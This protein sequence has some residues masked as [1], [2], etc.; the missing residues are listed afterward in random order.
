LES[1]LRDHIEQRAR[2]GAAPPA[3]FEEAVKALG[4]ANALKQEF[5]KVRSRVHKRSFNFLFARIC[6]WG[7]VAIVGAVGGWAVAQTETSIEA[8]ALR[9]AVMLVTVLYFLKLPYLYR[10][11]S[12]AGVV[13]REIIRFASILAWPAWVYSVPAEGGP[14]L[15]LALLGF[16]SIV[17]ALVLATSF[18]LEQEWPEPL[19]VSMLP[20]GLDETT[21][22]MLDVAR[23]EALQ[24]KHDFI[25]TEHLLLALLREEQ[26]PAARV[27]AS[28]GVTA[29]AAVGA[30]E[31]ELS[32]GQAA[33]RDAQAL[34]R[35]PR[36]N[37]ALELAANEARAMGR[38]VI[39]A[40]HLFLGLLLE[41]TGVAA[42]VLKRLGANAEAV[43]QEIRKQL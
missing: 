33:P 40:E 32:A 9:L 38:D 25:G 14:V 39:N 37:R 18:R 23:T 35:T 6:C 19:Q 1:H 36:A 13:S 29:V 41:G 42:R 21:K 34:P 7:S 26:S 17:P 43:R 5:G 20:A 10:R 24:L 15:H 30:V 8:R 2:E 22:R 3:V 27:M 16:G 31:R 11:I 4:E 28:T 12:H